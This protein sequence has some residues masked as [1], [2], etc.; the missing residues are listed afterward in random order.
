[1]SE[2]PR[3]YLPVTEIGARGARSRS[4]FVPKFYCHILLENPLRVLRPVTKIFVSYVQSKVEKIRQKEVHL[5]MCPPHMKFGILTAKSSDFVH[6][7]LKR[8]LSGTYAA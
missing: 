4:R 1:M 2:Q 3:R 6:A 7:F 5:A 8:L